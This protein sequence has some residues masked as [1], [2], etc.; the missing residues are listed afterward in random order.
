MRLNTLST[1]I[2]ILAVSA[3]Q[4]QCDTAQIFNNDSS[5]AVCIETIDNVIT[6]HTNNYPDHEW[7][8]WPSGN[9]V[10]SQR[11]S[12]N[13][14][15]YPIKG[16]SAISMY[17]NPS[18]R[19]RCSEYMIV[20]VGLNGIFY[21]GWGAMWFVNPNTMEENTDWNVEASE[22]FN[23]DYNTAHSNG[24]GEYHYHGTPYTYYQDDLDI[25]GTGHSPLIGYTADGFPMYYKYVYSDP[26]DSRSEI[27]SIESGYTL[28]TGNR[29]GDGITAPDGAYTG[30]YVEDY[31]FT[32][33]SGP[34]DD[35]NGRY[36]VTPDFPQGTYYYVVTDNWPNFPRC[37]YGTVLD[38]SFRIGGGCPESTADV[39]CSPASTNSVEIL[40]GLEL[41]LY[42]NPTGNYIS[43][44]GQSAV[45]ISQLSIYDQLGEILYHSTTD[46]QHIDLTSWSVGTYYMQITAGQ[47]EITRKI[48]KK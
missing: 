31:E 17:E 15:A 10:S 11:F 20:G 27:I 8:N 36:G 12:Y 47:T 46:F 23:M 38:N 44:E 13:V 14:C 33:T 24:D 5:N 41:K 34:V 43:I 1:F 28:K 37:F 9:P 39:D 35:C 16:D 7:G 45:H 42:P 6:I 32:K 21:S 19:P 30:L 29:P 18:E 4:A 48:I 22:M 40:E 25:D 3:V 2:A 26:L